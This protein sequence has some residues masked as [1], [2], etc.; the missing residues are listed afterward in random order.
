MIKHSSYVSGDDVELSV[1]DAAL[2][3]ADRARD[4]IKAGIAA[5]YKWEAAL[6]ARPF[7]DGVKVNPRKEANSMG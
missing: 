6:G 5:F 2:I 4:D 7:W 1:H 3:Q